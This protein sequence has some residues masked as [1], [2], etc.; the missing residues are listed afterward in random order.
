MAYW[1]VTNYLRGWSVSSSSIP[2]DDPLG[3]PRWFQ[4][5][6]HVDVLR[7]NQTVGKENKQSQ[8]WDRNV[9][10][11]R[12]AGR[13]GGGCK[14]GL[15]EHSS[16]TELYNIRSCQ[17]TKFIRI[18]N[19]QYFL[20]SVCQLRLHFLWHQNLSCWLQSMLTF[21][22]SKSPALKSTSHGLVFIALQWLPFVIN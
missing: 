17:R 19:I 3:S 21:P 9:W 2:T 6:G 4:A 11:R 22:F 18:Q 7:S 15:R 1:Q 14:R 20:I 5:H 16:Q 10:G 13:T 12:E 8:I